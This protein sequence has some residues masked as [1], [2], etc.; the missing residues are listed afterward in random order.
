ML[1]VILFILIVMYVPFRVF[2]LTVLFCVLFVRKY[3]LTTATGI[4]VHF[5]TTL[6]EVFPCFFLSS[7]ANARV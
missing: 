4:S 3:V 6:T 1:C 2:C 7:K 5:S